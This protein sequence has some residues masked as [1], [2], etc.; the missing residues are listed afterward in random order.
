MSFPTYVDTFHRDV[1]PRIDAS[2]PELSMKGKRVVITGGAGGIGGAAA[3]AFV[4]AG[5]AEVVIIGRT[6]ATLEAMRDDLLKVRGDVSVLIL[7][8]D[9]SSPESVRKAIRTLSEGAKIDIF[10]NNAGYATSSTTVAESDADDWWKAVE[11]NGRGSFEMV[12][13][14]VQIASNDAVMINVTSAVA[15]L[16]ALPGTSAY[17]VSKIASTKLFEYIQFENPGFRVFNLQPG[18]IQTTAMS[19]KYLEE[20]GTVYPNQDTG[21]VERRI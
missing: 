20:G 8:A 13:G 6:E 1:Y 5:A 14:M 7:V 9:V 19:K 12:K 18:I 17:G 15:H 21:K 10:V 16:P 11:V 2:R 3:K 4:V